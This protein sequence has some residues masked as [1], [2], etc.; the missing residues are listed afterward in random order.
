MLD[1]IIK[2]AEQ[3]DDIA[4][5]WL[6]GS[7]ARGDHHANSDYDLA[8]VFFTRESDSLDRRLKPEVK[9]LEWQHAQGVPEGTMSMVDLSTCP[10]T[11]GWSILSEGK[12]LVNKSPEVRLRAESRIYSMWELDYQYHQTRF[13]SP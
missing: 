5:L 12:L 11:L 8:V 9:A 1:R 13:G 6:Y 4:A 2:L 10:V 7:R 3:D